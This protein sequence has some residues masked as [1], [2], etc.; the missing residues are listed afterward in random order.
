[1]MKIIKNI[2]AVSIISALV[3]ACSPG[4]NN[5]GVEYA[6]QMYH[7][8]PYEPLTQIT[9]T[10]DGLIGATYYETFINST[11]YNDYNG[12][13]PINSLKPVEGTVARQNYSS[14]TNSNVSYPGQSLLIYDIHK[15]SVAQ[16]GRELKNPLPNTP[17]IV[18]E[19]KQLYLS[20]C[21]HCHGKTGAGDGK[22]GGI[23]GGVP[24][25]SSRSVASLPEGHVFHVITH[26]IR[27]M[28]PHKSQLNPEERWKIVRYVQKLQKG[29]Q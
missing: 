12:N 22:V 18:A 26:G 6:P 5:P 27:R 7:S 17:D 21:S 13:V 8:I 23:Y 11:P 1:M 24:N 2:L 16:A 4:G 20:Y 15:D 28:W 19:G 10:T 29:E 25:Y 3:V 14:V 9:E